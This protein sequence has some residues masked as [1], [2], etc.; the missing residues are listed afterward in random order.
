MAEHF[1]VDLGAGLAVEA[2]FTDASDGDFRVRSPEPGLPGRRQAIVDRPW[3]WIKQVH[4]NQVLQVSEPGQH[5]GEEADGLYTTAFGC[6]IAVTTADCAPVL[7]VA[8]RG[9]AVVH[10]GWRGLVEGI[11]ERAGERLTAVAGRPVRAYLGPCI[12]PD[13]YEF[14]RSELNL[15]ID[16]LG[17]TVESVTSDG[18]LALDMPSAVGAACEAAG[19]E[20]PETPACTSDTKFFSHRTRADQGRQTLVAWLTNG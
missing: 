12:G 3:S 15:V 13:A 5:G 20:A 10:A 19:W 9:V 1:S 2:R 4:G 16:R 17:S 7:L 6:P 14:G 11:I 8:E 18:A